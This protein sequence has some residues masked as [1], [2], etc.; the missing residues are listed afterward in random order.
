MPYPKKVIPNISSIGFDI[1]KVD[2][3]LNSFNLHHVED[4]PKLL[5][6]FSQ[7]LNPGWMLLTIFITIGRNWGSFVWKNRIAYHLGSSKES[8]MRIGKALFGWFDKKYNKKAQVKWDSLYADRYSAFYRIMPMNRVYRILREVGFEVVEAKPSMR[9][10]DFLYR[11]SK[12]GKARLLI[13]A[14]RWLPFFETLLTFALR[15]RQ[16]LGNGD[17]RSLLCV[18]TA[19]PDAR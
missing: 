11:R 2:F 12:N 18:R 8:R 1:D 4:Y 16:Y 14:M 17:T 9:A 3:V 6:V 7:L 10:Y 13:K 19:R 15:V 5:S